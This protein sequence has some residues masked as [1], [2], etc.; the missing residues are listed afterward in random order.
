MFAPQRSKMLAALGVTALLTVAFVYEGRAPLAGQ[1]AAA[2]TPL[3]FSSY[4]QQLPGTMHKITPAD[5]PAPNEPQ[6]AYYGPKVVARPAGAMPKTMS[7]F[8]V[9]EY[10]TGLKGPRLIR[11]APNGDLFIAEMGLGNIKVLHGVAGGKA[12]TIETF[13]TG[14][15]QPFGI[16]FYPLGPN[17]QYVYVGE[18]NALV[19]F[20]YK[21]GDLKASG[22][23]E[24]LADLPGSATQRGGHSTRTLD[25]SLDGKRLFVAVGSLSNVDDTDTHPLEKERADVLEFAPDG[26]GRRI[27]AYG[28]RNCVGLA[29]HPTTGE[30]WCSTNERDGLGDDLVPDYITHV[31]EGGF[32]GWPWFY[33][34]GNQDPRHA[35][36]HSELKDKVIVPDV[37]LQPHNA[38][39]QLT[40]YDG[41]QFPAEYQGDIFAAEHGSW[42]RSAR[43]GYEVIRVPMKNGKATGEYEDFLT[44]FVVSDTEVWGRPVGVAVATDGALLV[45]DDASNTVWRIAATK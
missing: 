40:F 25:F 35:G 34:G 20:P 17:P 24:K 28:I 7:G 5:L 12:Q 43:T 45:T 23:K 18:T 16:A 31:Q 9:T 41:K 39:L 14:L 19:R 26:S 4:K 36:K 2:G 32:Y 44:G 1:Q 6:S 30:V 11:K 22:P 37:L 42:N 3:V 27:F 15:V 10:A 29:V 8:T 13:A 21:N 38:S 33:I